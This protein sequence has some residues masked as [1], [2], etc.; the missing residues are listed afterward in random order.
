MKDVTPPEER[1]RLDAATTP[2]PT[3]R[4]DGPIAA[5]WRR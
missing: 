3:G 2:E 5:P 1:D 4:R